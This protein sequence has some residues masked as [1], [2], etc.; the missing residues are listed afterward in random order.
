MS[1]TFPIQKKTISVAM[2]GCGA[3]GRMLLDT[4]SAFDDVT[5]AAVCDQYEDR[6]TRAQDKIESLRGNRPYGTQNY[7]EVLAMDE[8][9]AVVIATPWDDHIRMTIETLYAGK[10]AAMEVGGA[11][12]LEECYALV[13]AVEETGTPMMFMENCCFDRFELLATALHRAGRFG[14]VVH[15]HGA[16]SHDLRDE[17]LGGY[18]NRHYRIDNYLRRNGENYPTHELGPIARL[19][20]INRGNRMVSLV[21]V[22]SKAAGLTAFSL[23]DKNPDPS[24]S[25]A[26]FAQGDIVNTII[27]CANGETITLTLDTTL[28]KYYSR[29]FTVRG[30]KGLAM[31]EGNMVMLEGDCNTHIPTH[32]SAE[33]YT[34]YLPDIWKNITDEQLRLGHGGMDFLEFR[35]FFSALRGE[36]DM[37]ID[38]YDA[39]A[40]MS[41]TVLSERSIAQGGAPQIIPDFTNGKWMT[42][43]SVD[44][45]PLPNPQA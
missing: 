32:G 22:A 31:Q 27:T 11:Y 43:K 16:Y 41:V 37:P 9:D 24:L 44:V 10:A 21:S 12:D 34:D 8:I 30:T 7:R 14:E 1:S 3:R 2:V 17:I 38:V 36:R 19:L 6:V 28:P 25:G 29:E 18:V 15:C 4:L 20:D 40:W 33:N 42:R 23:T 39:V 26:K 5:I 13:R 45:V 35:E